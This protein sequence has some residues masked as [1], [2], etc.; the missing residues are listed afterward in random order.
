MAT[1]K[2]DIKPTKPRTFGDDVGP[3]NIPEEYR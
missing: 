2:V 1:K 3:G